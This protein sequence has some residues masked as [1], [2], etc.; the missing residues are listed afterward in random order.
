MMVS[1]GVETAA[2][3]LMEADHHQK[4]SGIEAWLPQSQTPILPL[5]FFR[6]QS[7]KAAGTQ[8]MGRIERRGREWVYGKDSADI[9]PG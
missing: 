5:L 8:A 9:R 2:S 4:L 1:T 3:G 6:Q 7:K